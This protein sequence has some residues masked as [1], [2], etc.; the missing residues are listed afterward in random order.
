MCLVGLDHL[1]LL[2]RG[3]GLVVVLVDG[4]SDAGTLGGAY[5]AVG[6]VE[7]DGGSADAGEGVAEQ[8]RQEHVGPSGV[9]VA[10]VHAHLLHHLHAVAEGEDD[11]L[12]GGAHE[13]GLRVLVEVQPVD[14]A[15]HLAV[16]Q[17]ALS[18]VA[19]GYDAHALAADGCLCCQVVHLGIADGGGD[20]AVHPG[21]EYAGAVDA[22][23]HAQT[24]LRVDAVV[25]VG[26]G[27]DA[28]PGVVVHLAEHAVDDAAGACRGCYLAG[29]EHVE[30]QGVVGLVATAIG[31]GRAGLQPQLLG[32]GGAD[33]ALLAERGHDVGYQAAV[34]A[35]VVEQELCHAVL[36][37]V[38]EHAFR[39]SAD[40]G[41]HRARQA[42]GQIVAGQHH[43]VY[44]A[45]HLGLVILHPCQLG[46][47]EVA[48]RVEQMAQA[49]VGAQG[50]E[51][52]LAVGHGA[53]VAP[54]DGGAQGPQ[55]AV[56]AHQS[57]HLVADA[58]GGYLVALHA[59][60]GHNLLERLL[61][62]LPPRVGLLLGP[63]GLDGHDG[64]LLLGEEG[65]CYTLAAF[66][67]DQRC[68]DRR[69]ADIKT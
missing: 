42:H 1:Q 14:G 46:G 10:Y 32:G 58:D 8:R 44:L 5:R 63:S 31:D 23:Q 25:D 7:L 33:H 19:E 6:V 50:L 47:G 65:A 68:L 57:V 67:V 27:V 54:D 61:G 45:V 21:I 30:R 24:G 43:L 2:Q 26:K 53:R 13:V 29:V 52:L 55:V 40:G 51:G 37:E 16:L 41:V 49:L 22:Q 34:E 39:Q 62:V 20:V 28:R 38:P 59:A 56:H 35:V 11:A 12:L 66:G 4:G 69:T 3:E 64:G 15:A 17:H 36:L 18:A 60:V 48:G 9:D